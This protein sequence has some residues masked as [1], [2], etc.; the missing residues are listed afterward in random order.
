MPYS[1]SKLLKKKQEKYQN[2]IIQSLT[3]ICYTAIDLT[4]EELHKEAWK[5]FDQCMDKFYRYKTT[6][7]YRHDT[8]RGTRTGMNLYR[9][10]QF[11]INYGSDG[12]VSSVHIGWN[13]SDMKPYKP[14]KDINGQIH[15]VDKDYVLH[16]VMSGIRGLEDEYM[17]NGF[18]PYDNHWSAKVS[19]TH[20]GILEGTPNDIFDMYE[21]KYKNVARKLFRKHFQT[22]YKRNYKR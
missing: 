4:A 12:H 10:S 6:S 2:K 14:W 16:N 19:T 15:Q 18:A 9:A 5:I 8:G 21:Y 13:D 20:F 17:P 7:Y 11:R 1:A 3:E 22:V